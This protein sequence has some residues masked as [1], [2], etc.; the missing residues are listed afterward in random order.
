VCRFKSV[1]GSFEWVVRNGSA[2]FPLR[3]NVGVV[4][5]RTFVSFFLAPHFFSTLSFS[6]LFFGRGGLFF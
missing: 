4:I 2:A 1:V 6:F 3:E 5:F